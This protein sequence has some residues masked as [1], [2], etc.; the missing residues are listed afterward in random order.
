MGNCIA[1]GFHDFDRDRNEF[2]VINSLGFA[3]NESDLRIQFNE[4]KS[5]KWILYSLLGE[6]IKST[7]FNTTESFVISPKGLNSG[8]YFL[9]IQLPEGTQTIKLSSQ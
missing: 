5:G 8:I 3:K 6:V 7:D 1:V 4:S 2:K 9:Q